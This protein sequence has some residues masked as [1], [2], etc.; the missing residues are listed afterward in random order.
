MK[1]YL[2]PKVNYYI[3]SKFPIVEKLNKILEEHFEPKE[4]Q[5]NICTK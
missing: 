1:E 4:L 5:L 3:F 2:A